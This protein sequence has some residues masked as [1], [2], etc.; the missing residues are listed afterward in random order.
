[1]MRVH[2]DTAVVLRKLGSVSKT[3]VAS[4]YTFADAVLKITFHFQVMDSQ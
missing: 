1:M 3:I 2:P 4:A